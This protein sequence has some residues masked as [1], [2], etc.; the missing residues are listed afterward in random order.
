MK[1]VNEK[2]PDLS[3]DLSR[4]VKEIAC[5]LP[6]AD[7]FCGMGKPIKEVLTDFDAASRS[8][9]LTYAIAKAASAFPAR[10]EP[11]AAPNCN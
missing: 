10:V 1:G 11:G 4:V 6:N 8:L 5:A 7:Q 2:D 9:D 3:R